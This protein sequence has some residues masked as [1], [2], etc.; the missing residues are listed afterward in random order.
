MP[1]SVSAQQNA[2]KQTTAIL[3]GKVTD[4]ATGQALQGATIYFPD[5]RKGTLTNEKG[6]YQLQ[7]LGFV[8]IQLLQFY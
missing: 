2:N 7:L 5:T 8:Y 3:K 4:A 6:E 1:I